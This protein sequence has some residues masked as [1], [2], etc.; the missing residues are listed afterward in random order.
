MKRIEFSETAVDADGA[1]MAFRKYL[2]GNID[3][4]GASLIRGFEDALSR[5]L[6]VKDSVCVSSGTAGLMLGIKAL[7]LGGEVIVPSFTFSGTVNALAWN[8]IV[9]RFVDI[10]GASFN[11]DPAQV[12]RNI[13]PKTSAILAVH[14]FGNPCDIAGLQEIA[15]ESGIM[16]LFD[17]APSFGSRYDGKPLG[18]FGCLEVFSFQATKILSAME[19]GAITTNDGGLA[20][21]LRILRSQGN[22]GDGNCIGAGMNARMHP[23]AAIFG[24]LGLKAVERKLKAKAKLGGRYISL[25]SENEGLAFQELNPRSS[26]NYQYMPVLVDRDAFGMSRDILMRELEGAG[27]SARKYFHP[28][29]HRFDCYRHVRVSSPL[30]NTEY[31][32]ENILCLPFYAS[33]RPETIGYVC[34]KVR[35]IREKVT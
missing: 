35:R 3:R 23:A 5:R 17:S 9:P 15:E 22:R 29:V 28:P 4:N 34:E 31:V 8:G 7:G 26:Y 33:M 13:T 30:T 1:Q 24:R 16:L 12:R 20:E 19:G 2:G 32:S 6:G 25:L 10:D 11:I 27:I 18:G 14:T 21:R